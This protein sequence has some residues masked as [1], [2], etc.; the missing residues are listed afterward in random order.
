MRKAVLFFTNVLLPI[1][2]PAPLIK[3]KSKVARTLL[4]CWCGR[5]DFRPW[6]PLPTNSP[7]DCSVLRT[8]CRRQFS[9]YFKS[10][11]PYKAKE[12]SHKDS[13]LLLVRETGLEP[14]RWNHT[15]LKRA[16]LPVPPLPR[17][18]TIIHKIGAFVKG[19]C[20]SFSFFF[21]ETALR[22]FFAIRYCNLSD[23]PL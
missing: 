22:L 7:P 6:R 10:R 20:K 11:Y 3:Q 12:Q 1:S 4:F 23:F 9:P 19:F 2:S 8:N 17:T 15:P 16:R 14:V 13:A 18:F 21:C 5:R